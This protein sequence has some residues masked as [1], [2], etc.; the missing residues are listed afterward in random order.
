MTEDETVVLLHGAAGR[1]ST[2]TA[3]LRTWQHRSRSQRAFELA[4]A[5]RIGGAMIHSR[6]GGLAPEESEARWRVAHGPGG[7]YRWDEIS[8]S[9]E[10]PG[11]RGTHGSDGERAWF[12]GSDAVHLT[13]PPGAGLLHRLLDPA[14]VLT[15]DLDVRG[16]TE[17][18]AR[19][20]LEVRARA[21]PFRLA[22]GGAADMAAERDLVVDAERGFLHRDAAL[23]E[24]EP[25]DVMVLRE[26]V[27]DSPIDPA[28]FAPHVPPG[29]PV[30]DHTKDPP[31]PP[32]WARRRR[33]HVQW[34]VTRW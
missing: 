28:A 31:P 2:L 9:G 3:E 4:H 25:Y 26:I 12:V 16:E 24:G 6:Q 7:R 34:P 33:W 13:R 18:N 21:R 14:W 27:L 15:H 22:S 29:M 10:G 11:V 1:S 19:P 17:S 8:R 23:V 30:H 5:S 32:P 20:A